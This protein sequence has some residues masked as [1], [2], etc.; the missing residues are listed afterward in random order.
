MILEN[1]NS[2]QRT[3]QN[4]VLVFFYFCLLFPT[5]RALL[6]GHEESKSLYQLFISAIP[7][8]LILII[9][10]V[11]SIQLFLN[12]FPVLKKIDWVVIGFAVI[13]IVYGTWLAHDFKIAMYAVRMSYLPI[14]FYFVARFAMN[15]ESINTEKFLSK[16]LF[17]LV[18]VAVIGMLLYFIFPFV[19]IYMIHKTG[20]V[21]NEYFIIRMTS[22][23]WSPV[24]FGTMM[25]IGIL[26]YYYKVLQH[27]S[28]IYF[29]L[30]L[31][32]WAC[33]LLSVSRGPLVSIIV[34]IIA[35]TIFARKW[36]TT[37]YVGLGMAVLFYGFTLYTSTN[38]SKSYVSWLSE[39]SVKTVDMNDSMTR[40]KF[41]NSSF[42][43]FK[44]HPM[45]NG[46]GTAGHTGARFLNNNLKPGSAFSTDGWYL[47]Q[48]VETGII[49]IA[50]FIIMAAWIFL[51][52]WKS[53]YQKPFSVLTFLFVFFIM[54][55]I[56]D[57]VSNVSDFYWVADF[58]WLLIG[59]GINEIY[60]TRKA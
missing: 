7:E 13:N 10:G 35:L 4:F 2:G 25:A 11:V 6:I 33:L 49:G 20:G 50:T 57:L 38:N 30:V 5:L 23:L 40:V 36:K 46:L 27:F 14:I 3:I 34:G 41:W 21:V 39:S 60:S 29:L 52:M 9:A 19:M 44:K 47:K 58:Y 1:H 37:L 51:L 24:L 31:I 12:P 28:W 15:K 48:A 59:I 18:I 42:D 26:F 16:L 22:I 53:V 8:L 43:A 54:I 32:C 45:G 56:Q 17:S 55:R